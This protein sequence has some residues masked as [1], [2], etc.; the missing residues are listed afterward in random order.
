MTFR[1][2]FHQSLVAS[3][4]LTQVP[5]SANEVFS[6]SL[7]PA[8]S[9][10]SSEVLKK[11]R[12][13]EPQIELILQDCELSHATR[14][15]VNKGIRF[16]YNFYANRLDYN[17]NREVVVKIRIFG[18]ADSYRNYLD[19]HYPLIPKNWVGVYLSSV[20]EILVSLEPDEKSFYQNI[21]HETSHLL[22]SSRIKNCPNWVNEGLAE[23][24]EYMEVTDAGV[25]VRPQLVKDR[26]T[27]RWLTGKTL[28]DVFSS[29]GWSNRDWNTADGNSESDEPRTIAWSVASFLMSSDKGVAFLQNLIPY[30]AKYPGDS[31]ASLRA[32]DS[33]YPGG[34]RQFEKDWKHW[35]SQPRK[36]QHITA[37][38]ADDNR[39]ASFIKSIFG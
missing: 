36:E 32:I 28:P 4:L 15:K 26:R 24:F 38:P 6:P 14:E 12:T 22:L 10:K 23:Y 37:P 34:R 13:Y 5:V 30:L 3:M 16:L 7:A 11:R 18:S 9:A 29:F 39:T 25:V 33:Y 35:V 19:A 1:K 20:N 21:F 8:P 17:F 2:F 27:K 31:K